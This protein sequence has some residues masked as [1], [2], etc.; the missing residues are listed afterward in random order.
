MY[1]WYTVLGCDHRYV[2]YDATLY[3]GR[4]GVQYWIRVKCAI[5][6]YWAEIMGTRW[7]T[8]NT[9][10]VLLYFLMSSRLMF[11]SYAMMTSQLEWVWSWQY[12][13]HS[14]D[15]SCPGLTIVSGSASTKS[16]EI[17]V[18]NEYRQHTSLHTCQFMLLLK[19]AS[20]YVSRWLGTS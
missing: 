4:E 1:V 14:N 17:V 7:L 13:V 9:Q 6:L 5:P 19:T 10:I 16:N 8:Q 11:A 18:E 12:V 20:M 15:Q 2:Q 3:A